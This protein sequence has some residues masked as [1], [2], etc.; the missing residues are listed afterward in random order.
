MKFIPSE[1]VT[2][3]SSSLHCACFVVNSS[4]ALL[5]LTVSASSL[6]KFL[7]LMF[8]AYCNTRRI[9]LMLVSTFARFAISRHAWNNF[10]ACL[11]IDH[12][13]L[14]LAQEFR[15]I[16]GLF[17][18]VFCRILEILSDYISASS[19]SFRNSL[20]LLVFTFYN[21]TFT[22]FASLQCFSTTPLNEQ[23]KWND[24]EAVRCEPHFLFLD[25]RRFSV[26]VSAANCY[27]RQH[28]A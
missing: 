18:A 2:D 8:S 11:K 7:R 17:R 21:K 22:F 1:N 16:C 12:L 5:C 4:L 27:L 20:V 9:L 13:S 24:N 25:L 10:D 6:Y 14:S 28:R 3:C 15:P 23:Q 19:K 26:N